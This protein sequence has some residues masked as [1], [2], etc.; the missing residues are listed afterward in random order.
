LRPPFLLLKTGYN[1][2]FFD[3]VVNRK[4][5]LGVSPFFQKV[6]FS[7]K[8]IFAIR[9]NFEKYKFPSPP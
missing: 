9:E 4:E 3:A 7:L 2:R 6:L 8:N 5:N 1:Y